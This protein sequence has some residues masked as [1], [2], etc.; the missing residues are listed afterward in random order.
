MGV[1]GGGGWRGWGWRGGGGCIGVLHPSIQPSV[2]LTHKPPHPIPPHP[3]TTPPLIIADTLLAIAEETG[4]TPAQV[5]LRWVMQRPGV[6]C[7][8]IGAKRMDQLEDNIAATTLRLTEA[9]ME[10]LNKGG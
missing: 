10:A 2:V 1:G 6:T 9:Q 4:R 5:A 7:P 8:V 3:S